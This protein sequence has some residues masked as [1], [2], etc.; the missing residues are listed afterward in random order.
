MSSRFGRFR[1]RPSPATLIA[2]GVVILGFV[3]AV[4]KPRWWSR[5]C[6]HCPSCSSFFACAL[7]PLAFAC[8]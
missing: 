8:S 5:T 1:W 3:L 4:E 6:I 2:S 7:S